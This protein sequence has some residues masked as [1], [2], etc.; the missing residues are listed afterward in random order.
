MIKYLIATSFW[1]FLDFLNIRGINIKILI[2]KHNQI[3]THELDE[4]INKIE[5]VSKKKKLKFAG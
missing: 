5:I 3:I 2:S 1:Y 4:I